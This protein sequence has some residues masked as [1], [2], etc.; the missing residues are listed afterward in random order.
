MSVQL[1]DDEPLETELET[2]EDVVE[3]S[4]ETEEK[5]ISSEEGQLAGM[6]VVVWVLLIIGI[7]VFVAST[8]IKKRSQAEVRTEY[9]TVVSGMFSLSD[10]TTEENTWSD[11]L[12]V[13]KKVQGNGSTIALYLCGKAE[14]Y[15]E[16]VYIP[17]TQEEFNSVND[18]DTV[19]F[20]F[21][22]LNI[23]NKEYIIIR[24]WSTT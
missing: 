11:T 9:T 22:R 6:L 15:G 3:E 12:T 5:T 10:V 18:G 23:E 2:G 19:S 17:V 7:V 14:N 21:S 8:I 4:G 16:V 13:S 1:D 20:N 24:R